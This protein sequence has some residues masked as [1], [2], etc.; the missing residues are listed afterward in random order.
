MSY[1]RYAY[2]MRRHYNYLECGTLYRWYMV[3]QQSCVC[4]CWSS[5]RCLYRYFSTM[6][7]YNI[8]YKYIRLYQH[9]YCMR[10]DRPCNSYGYA[11][12][13]YMPARQYCT[14][15]FGRSCRKFLFMDINRY[16]IRLIK[17]Y[18]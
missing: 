3:E 2:C 4:Y 6:L 5:H 1:Y 8:L 11:T 12:Y 15:R 16:Y 10:T 18:I 14:Y 17:L 7:R 9:N 13:Q